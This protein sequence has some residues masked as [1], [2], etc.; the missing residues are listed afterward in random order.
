MHIVNGTRPS[1][2]TVFHIKWPLFPPG[3]GCF[4]RTQ[5]KHDIKPS[6]ADSYIPSVKNI[7]PAKMIRIF[8]G[9]HIVKH[10]FILEW[11]QYTFY[12]ETAR[13]HSIFHPRTMLWYQSFCSTS[14]SQ[15]K[16]IAKDWDTDKTV[17]GLNVQ[18]PIGYMSRLNNAF[19]SWHIKCIILLLAG[20]Y[21]YF[22]HF[23][24][25]RD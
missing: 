14:I 5:V 9:R 19:P 21:Q 2:G 18:N 8:T 24:L 11:V 15:K 10:Q 13:N 1:A 6:S 22:P 20:K 25:S 7:H 17:F 3:C 12:V 4:I 23:P 16:S